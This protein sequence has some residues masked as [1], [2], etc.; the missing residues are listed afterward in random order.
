[1]LLLPAVCLL[2]FGACDRAPLTGEAPTTNATAATVET[3]LPAVET[4]EP[5]ASDERSALDAARQASELPIEEEIA[6]IVVDMQ[7]PDGA[8]FVLGTIEY[9]QWV[10]NCAELAGESIRVELSPPAVFWTTGTRTNA[11]VD[12]CSAAAQEQEWLVPYPFD[13]SVEGNRLEYQLQ[14]GVYECLRSNGYPTVDPPSEEAF[15][16]G[17]ADWNAYAAMGQ[18]VP[19]YT[20]GDP[21]PGASEQLDAQRMC[22]SDLATLYQER[23]IEADDPPP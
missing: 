12:A 14:L 20:N 8:R 7:P 10:Q 17:E 19:L 6:A 4:S 3:S 22:G 18:G 15:V 1:M 13:G 2:F 9:F 11:V 23:V 21:A 5:P 16:A